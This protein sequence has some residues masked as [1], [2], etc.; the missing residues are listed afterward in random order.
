[1]AKS[2][3][4]GGIFTSSCGMLF[5]ATALDRTLERQA[6]AKRRDIRE[7]RDL[8]PRIC[9]V[10]PDLDSSQK[11]QRNPLKASILCGGLDW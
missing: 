8:G 2:V 1:M 5:P 3:A 9:R 10:D 6:R 4:V 11:R 7:P